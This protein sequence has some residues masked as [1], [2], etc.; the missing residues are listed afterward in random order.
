MSKIFCRLKAFL[1]ITLSKGTLH[2]VVSM[3]LVVPLIAWTNSVAHTVPRQGRK[4][5]SLEST[6]NNG[7]SIA[8]DGFTG[9]ENC[10]RCMC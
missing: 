6:G 10:L 9:E 5:K 7:L 8:S 4:E 1:P 3:M 2:L